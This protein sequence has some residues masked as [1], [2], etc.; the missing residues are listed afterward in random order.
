MQTSTQ[1]HSDTSFTIFKPKWRAHFYK[2][3]SVNVWGAIPSD[4]QRAISSWYAA[5]YNSKWSKFIIQ[6]Y[7]R[8]NYR[9]NNYLSN[10]KPPNGKK[11]FETFQDFFT[12]EF[13]LIPTNENDVVWPCEGLLCEE[14]KVSRLRHVKV[15]NDL[16]TIDTVFGLKEKTIPK[17]YSFTNVFLHNKN[18]HRIHAPISGTIT[19]IQHIPGDLIVLRPWIYKQNPSLPAFRNERYNIDITDN[20]D[21]IWYLSIVGGPAVGTI[22]LDDKITVGAQVKKL[23]ELALFHLGSTCCMAAPVSPRFN[24]KNTF[25]ALGESY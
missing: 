1:H 10:F 20:N 21:T 16:R 24:S 3:L 11:E 7:I 18:Y 15:K 8:I 25:V 19:R 5:I 17:Q 12:R 13:K 9:D 14:N 2:F 23:N 4:I 6:P 22:E